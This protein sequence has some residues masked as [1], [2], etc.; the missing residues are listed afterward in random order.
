MEGGLHRHGPFLTHDLGLDEQGVADLGDLV[1]RELDVHDR[2]DDPGDV[3]WQS[4]LTS[5][6]SG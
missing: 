5:L 1:S 2:A 6:V 4:C 3:Q